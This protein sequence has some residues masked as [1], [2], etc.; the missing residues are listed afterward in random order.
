MNTQNKMTKVGQEIKDHPILSIMATI[1]STAAAVWITTTFATQAYVNGV[2][3]YTKQDLTKY[4]DS[5]HDDIKSDIIDIKSILK[6][7]EERQYS[8]LKKE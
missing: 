4:V 6:R 1:I 7:I 5:R 2:A 8:R 3:K